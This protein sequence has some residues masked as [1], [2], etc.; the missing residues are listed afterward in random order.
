MNEQRPCKCGRYQACDDEDVVVVGMVVVVVVV[1]VVVMVVVRV[2]A[3]VGGGG[4]CGWWWWVV[5]HKSSGSTFLLHPRLPAPLW[6]VTPQRVN[7]FL[8]S[9][10][11]LSMNTLLRML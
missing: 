4:W 1:M 5:T 10:V 6:H 2:V 3:R 11:A 9:G 7:V 8:L